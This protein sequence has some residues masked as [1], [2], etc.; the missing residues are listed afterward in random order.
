MT[1]KNEKSE[2]I[3]KSVR[4]V[5]EQIKNRYT[6]RLAAGS[7]EAGQLEFDFMLIYP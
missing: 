3:E 5:T 6:C 7:F 2:Q 1:V 4:S